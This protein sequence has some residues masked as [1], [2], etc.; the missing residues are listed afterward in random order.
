MAPLTH[1][2]PPCIN[3]RASRA[4]CLT[5]AHRGNRTLLPSHQTSASERE[6]NPPFLLPPLR[7]IGASLRTAPRLPNPIQPVDSG[8][9][10]LLPHARMVLD[11]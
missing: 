3:D 6:S 1:R 10:L 11:G 2:I 4:F 5:R 8:R 9:L 7:F